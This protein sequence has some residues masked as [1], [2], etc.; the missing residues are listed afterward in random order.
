[1]RK[2]LP[3]KIYV[4]EI[5]ETTTL[6]KDLDADTSLRVSHSFFNS[7]YI[8]TEEIHESVK[9]EAPKYEVSNYL[10][11]A[12][13]IPVQIIV[14]KRLSD[15]IIFNVRRKT[16]FGYIKSM[17]FG[18]NSDLDNVNSIIAQLCKDPE[19]IHP[20]ANKELSELMP[21]DEIVTT[22]APEPKKVLLTTH[23]NV[24]ITDP[25]QMVYSVSMGINH[26]IIT[27]TNKCENTIRL[28]TI[29][30]VVNFANK[31][32]REKYI[33]ENAPCLSLKDVLGIYYLS[34]K[35]AS[36]FRDQLINFVNKKLNITS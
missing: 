17:V 29:A 6:L 25:E 21:V 10:P 20:I 13:N 36:C 2:G 28:K 5:T 23:D 32:N 16:N 24:D 15:G 19:L 11:G 12:E 31:E 14:A 33:Y 18:F 8:V 3:V 7:Q 4:S 1:M 35:D 9:K 27:F 26:G 30:E 22:P 34:D